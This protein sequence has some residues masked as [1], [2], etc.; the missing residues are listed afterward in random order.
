MIH[1]S[2][3]PSVAVPGL[4]RGSSHDRRLPVP[5]SLDGDGETPQGRGRKA[6]PELR[7]ADVPRSGVSYADDGA[8]A[9]ARVPHHTARHGCERSHTLHHRHAKVPRQNPLPHGNLA[10]PA[11][12]RHGHPEPVGCGMVV[13]QGL[14][15]SDPVTALYLPCGSLVLQSCVLEE[16]K[17]IVDPNVTI[18]VRA[19]R[20]KR[21]ACRSN[22]SGGP[23]LVRVDW[24]QPL[25]PSTRLTCARSLW[26]SAALAWSNSRSLRKTTIRFGIPD[27]CSFGNEVDAAR[28]V[29]RH[30]LLGTDEVPQV[31]CWNPYSAESGAYFFATLADEQAV[32]LVYKIAEGMHFGGYHWYLGDIPQPSCHQKG[33]GLKSFLTLDL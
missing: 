15:R 27:M 33:R 6:E 9:R 28:W 32:P 2:P 17:R 1:G 11:L 4:P 26:G 30:Y 7:G 16:V 10:R 5:V 22:T 20:D 18:R 3:P 23:D 8:L 24:T 14:W 13:R 19:W 29:H 21:D 25:S 31:V 12:A